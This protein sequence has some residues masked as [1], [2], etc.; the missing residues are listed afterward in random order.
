MAFIHNHSTF[1]TRS[2]HAYWNERL[3]QTIVRAGKGDIEL[4][5]TLAEARELRSSLGEAIAQAERLEDE[6]A[7]AAT[8]AAV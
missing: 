4:A 5:M 2:A 6:H 1:D 8:T 7:L 3:A